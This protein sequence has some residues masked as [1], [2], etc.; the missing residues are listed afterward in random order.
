MA[1]HRHTNAF[2]DQKLQVSW[3]HSNRREHCTSIPA[4]GII[5]HTPGPPDNIP[6]NQICNEGRSPGHE[7]PFIFPPLTTND[8]L[9]KL[10]ATKGVATNAHLRQSRHVVQ[11][12]TPCFALCTD[13]QKWWLKLTLQSIAS[14]PMMH[15][16]TTSI[17]IP[18][19]NAFSKERQSG[20][21]CHAKTWSF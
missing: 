16:T 1:A 6:K 3:A 14:G 19:L 5:L 21:S 18:P 12:C 4:R 11:L 20:H 15:H 13:S 9:S 8:A 7:R 17:T 10:R 2:D